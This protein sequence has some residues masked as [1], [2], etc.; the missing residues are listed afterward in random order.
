MWLLKRREMVRLVRRIANVNLEIVVGFGHSRN[1]V[2]AAKTRTA[3]AGKLVR[4]GPVSLLPLGMVEGVRVIMTA[5]P[6]IA[7]ESGQEKFV[8]SAAKT[9]TAQ[10]GKLVRTRPVSLP[11]LGMVEGVRVIMT[12]SRKHAVE[13]GH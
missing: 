2:S 8:A 12:A 1:A 3:Q 10:A 9:R 7:V 11:P 13:F 5:S 6:V 4:T